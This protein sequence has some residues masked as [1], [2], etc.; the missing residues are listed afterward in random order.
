M[1]SLKSCLVKFE[2]FF[3]SKVVVATNIA[4]TSITIEGISYVVDNCFVKL[5][6]YNPD[7]NVDALIV[8]EVSKSSAQQVALWFEIERYCVAWNIYLQDKEQIL[9]KLH[10]NLNV[11]NGT[12]QERP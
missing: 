8:T 7:N 10:K 6:W 11:H 5:K 2:I 3:F 4:E 1:S 12:L 9:F